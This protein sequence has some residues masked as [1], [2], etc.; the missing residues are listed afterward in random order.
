M[1][2]QVPSS[3]VNDVLSQ[4]DRDQYAYYQLRSFVEDNPNMSWCVGQVS[5]QG[6]T[7]RGARR[8]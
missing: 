1:C 6:A 4:K 7:V 5:Q 2:M 8:M 3:L